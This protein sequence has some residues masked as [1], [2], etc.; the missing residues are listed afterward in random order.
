MDYLINEFINYLKDVRHVSQNTIAAYK[1]DLDKLKD[2]Y[3]NQGISDVT[4]ISATN[5]NSY[6]LS[7]EKDG[8][9]PASVSRNIASIK[10]FL[11]FLLKK[12]L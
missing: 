11:L 12:V 8:M 9:K 10:A 7:L 3:E 4:K 6:I 1:N 5:L 2:F